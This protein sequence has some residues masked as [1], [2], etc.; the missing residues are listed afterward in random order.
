MFS[1]I[2]DIV[3]ADA[4]VKALLGDPVRLYPFGEAPQGV[5]KPYATY[6]NIGGGPFNYLNMRPDA[7]NIGLQIDVYGLTGASVTA[8]SKALNYALETQA[9][10]TRWGNE[11]RDPV[12]KNYHYDFD[13]EF[14]T[15]RQ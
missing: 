3:S 10:I 8:V 14:I 6:Q 1:P 13:V 11:N 4:A 5:A 7:D 15:D 2:F 12:T 9:Y